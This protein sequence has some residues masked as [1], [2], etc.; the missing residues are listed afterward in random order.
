MKRRRGVGGRGRE[1]RGTGRE[2]PARPREGE[3]SRRSR[4]TPLCNLFPFAS[5]SRPNV[6]STG[7]SPCALHAPMN[8]SYTTTTVF[9]PPNHP[10]KN[11][12]NFKKIASRNKSRPLS[13]TTSG[14]KSNMNARI[15]IALSSPKYSNKCPF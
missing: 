11:G 8:Q 13:R 15:F 7:G 14:T 9:H 3:A 10:R 6:E 2:S 1:A 4:W 12:E 5:A